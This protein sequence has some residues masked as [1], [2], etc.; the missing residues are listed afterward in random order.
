MK[1]GHKDVLQSELREEAARCGK[2]SCQ[3]GGGLDRAEEEDPRVEEG[4][5]KEDRG[6]NVLE[7]T[8][9]DNEVQGTVGGTN[10]GLEDNPFPL[11]GGLKT[12]GGGRERTV[13]C[14]GGESS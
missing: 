13:P 8:R 14:R 2:C 12:G 5:T 7:K 4:Q 3:D 11:P 6:G 10:S 1:T 9:V